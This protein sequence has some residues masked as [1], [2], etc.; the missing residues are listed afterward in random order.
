VS[1][2]RSEQ[3]LYDYVEANIDER[4]FWQYK[5]RK[6]AAGEPD[7]AGAALAIESELWRYYVERA[8]VVPLLRDVGDREGLRRVSMRNLAEHLI[9]SWV[10]PKASGKGAP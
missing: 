10:P 6:I 5:V 4:Q 3:R 7:P 2:N 8:G 1:L 9:R